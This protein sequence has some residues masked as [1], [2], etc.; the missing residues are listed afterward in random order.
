MKLL[1]A[2]SLALCFAALT[3][4]AA[5]Q[6][7][8]DWHTIDGGGG[9]SYGTTLELMG[10][11]GQHDPTALVATTIDISGG[12]WGVLVNNPCIADYNEDGFVDFFD[13]D[14]FIANFEAGLIPEADLNND[15]FIDW[16]DL[17]YFLEQFELGC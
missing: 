12:Y 17:D 6:L 10:T 7:A 2:M 11:I 14:L 16:F 8:I 15:Q 9:E 1:S 5:A 13:Y 3:P 4:R